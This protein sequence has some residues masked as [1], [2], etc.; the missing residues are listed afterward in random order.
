MPDVRGS[1]AEL[2][3]RGEQGL[4]IGEIATAVGGR[5]YLNSNHGEVGAWRNSLPA[6]LQVLRD[7]GLGHV[8][9]LLE[10]RLPYS[11]KRV[12]ALLCG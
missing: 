7:A 6:L 3:T 1:A 2:L 12:D 9:V 8:E 4:L 11:P 5:Y 10:Y